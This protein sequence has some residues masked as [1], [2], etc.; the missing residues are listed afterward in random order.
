MMV[1]QASQ[2]SYQEINVEPNAAPSSDSTGA[3]KNILGG[4]GEV[5]KGLHA[6]AETLISAS[7]LAPIFQTFDK[8][9]IHPLLWSPIAKLT[10]VDVDS[11]PPGIE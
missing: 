9:V 5:A 4:F 8:P 2:H 7:G 3:P 1:G 6:T 10:G 11:H